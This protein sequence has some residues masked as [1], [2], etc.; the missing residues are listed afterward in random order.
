MVLGAQVK[1]R[2]LRPVS[3]LSESDKGLKPGPIDP[4]N[5]LKNELTSSERRA[6][7]KV[8]YARPSELIKQIGYR[9]EI[10]NALECIV[11]QP[12][13]NYHEIVQRVLCLANQKAT[14]VQK[15]EAM[16]TCADDR[17]LSH[18][19]EGSV[20]SASEIAA[21]AKPA[22]DHWWDSIAQER[23][24]FRDAVLDVRAASPKRRAIRAKYGRWIDAALK[25]I[26]VVP[27]L[28][29]DGRCSRTELRFQS[30]SVRATCGFALMLL[31]DDH[32]P[33]GNLLRLCKLEECGRPFLG[34]S[35]RSGS[36]PSVYCSEECRTIEVR[37]QTAKRV[38]RLR[39]K[40][41]KEAEST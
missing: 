29:W 23:E 31:V 20:L 32:K 25:D 27:R 5:A 7:A 12:A 4:R 1:R 19:Y 33:L 17:L 15:A 39:E 24:V 35:H 2:L 16:V 11:K 9:H 40:R 8:E 21:K 28:T 36:R 37:D 10:Y 6:L 30:K 14:L 3:V 13:L 26:V 18:G 22:V 34:Q 41:A 38:A